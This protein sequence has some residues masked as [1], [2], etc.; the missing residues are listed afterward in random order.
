[1]SEK[2][3]FVEI[4]ALKTKTVVKKWDNF[5]GKNEF[6]R[7]SFDADLL[8]AQTAQKY[9]ASLINHISFVREAGQTIGV[10]IDQL[11]FHDDSKWTH[12]EFP[13]YANNFHG[14]PSNP[15]APDNFSAAWLHHIHHNPHHWQHWIFPDGF[16]PRNSCVENGIVQMP[17][18]YALEMIADWMGASMAYT[19]SWDMM[20]W[21]YKNMP[22]IRLHSKT[23]YSIRKQ[24]DMMSYADVVYAQRFGHEPN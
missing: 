9:A 5:N 11:M 8:N 12:E 23:A 1:M 15:N 18:F 6:T 16:T 22:N 24:L 19:G 10:D 14:D 3:L 20:E 17:E 21:L 4:E 7:L 13:H 2:I